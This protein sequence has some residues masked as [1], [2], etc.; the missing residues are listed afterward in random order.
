MKNLFLLVLLIS[1]ASCT[2][3]QRY[4]GLKNNDTTISGGG[5]G[6]IDTP[7]GARTLIYEPFDGYATM[8]VGNGLMTD[9]IHESA[10]GKRHLA[11]KIKAALP[12]LFPL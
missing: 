4:F 5:G 7:A 12:A 10:A 6:S 2:K 11:M 3:A 9:T 1:L 8:S